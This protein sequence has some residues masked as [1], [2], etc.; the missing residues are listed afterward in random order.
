MAMNA[1]AT[2][3][4]LLFVGD[5]VLPN[6]ASPLVARMQQPDVLTGSV[7]K[8]KFEAARQHLV[9]L[10]E[11]YDGDQACY[12]SWLPPGP[13]TQGV[14]ARYDAAGFPAAHSLHTLLAGRLQGSLAGSIAVIG[15]SKGGVVLR[16]MVEELAAWQRT[17]G[18]TCASCVFKRQ[19]QLTP[20]GAAWPATLARI[21]ELHWLDAGANP[22][23]AVYPSDLGTMK[24]LSRRCP[25]HSLHL[26]LH[27]T[28]RQWSD[29]RRPWLGQE[30]DAMLSACALA[31]VPCTTRLYFEGQPANLDMHFGVIQAFQPGHD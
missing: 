26:H 14:P 15:F 2:D 28:P 16:Q 21:R 6:A 11:R 22:P 8:A 29:P 23:G 19:H 30:K 18:M 9:V 1:A 31:G 24:L 25:S 13:L 27:G 5:R 7:L 20:A 17:A 3:A 10:P 4:V 12:T